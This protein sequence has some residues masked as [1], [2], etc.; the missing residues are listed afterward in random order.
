MSVVICVSAAEMFKHDSTVVKMVYKDARIINVAEGA[1]ISYVPW[2]ILGELK[3]GETLGRLILR[4]H[5]N[6]GEVYLAG[7]KHVPL[8]IRNAHVFA[9]LKQRFDPYARMV[10]VHSCGVASDRPYNPITGDGSWDG[11][12]EGAGYLFMKALANVTGA[13]VHAGQNTQQIP[14]GGKYLLGPTYWVYPDVWSGD[15][16]YGGGWTSIPPVTL[17]ELRK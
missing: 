3:P 14:W 13:P 6:A 17:E 7:T 10:F 12:G 5:G 11:S 4:G 2:R 9:P 1:V 15:K 8:S 16:N